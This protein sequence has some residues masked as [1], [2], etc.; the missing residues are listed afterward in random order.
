MVVLTLLAGVLSVVFGGDKNERSGQVLELEV[1]CPAGWKPDNLARSES[2]RL[3]WVQPREQDGEETWGELYLVGDG[4]L[5]GGVRLKKRGKARYL[6]VHA[7][8]TTDLSIALPALSGEWSAWAAAA[9]GY[10]YRVRV[11]P[12]EEY[13]R[14][15]PSPIEAFRAARAKAL[16][17]IGPEAPLADWLPFFE[18]ERGGPSASMPDPHPEYAV[19][20]SKAAGELG[21]LLGSKD[22]ETVRRAVLAASAL[23]PDPVPQAVVGSLSGAGRVVVDAIREARANGTPEDPDVVGEDRAYTLFVYW[24]RGDGEG[25]GEGSGEV[26]G[27]DCG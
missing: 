5:S 21:A 14:E 6:R 10:S 4:R 17:T 13:D 19:V 7:G 26:A 22:R 3:C 15:H 12:E 8:R 1:K 11:A 27:G 18:D 20:R 16:S 2:G 9:Q 23:D 25:G 24:D